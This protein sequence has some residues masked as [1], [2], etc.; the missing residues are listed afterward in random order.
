MSGISI[1]VHSIL[2]CISTGGPATNVIWTRGNDED[3]LMP[4]S[5]DT[6][7]SVLVNAATAQYNHTLNVSGTKLP[8]VYGCSV[9][10]NKPSSA[11][12]IYNHNY[13]KWYE[14]TSKYCTSLLPIHGCVLS[15]YYRV[16]Q[17]QSKSPFP[18]VNPAL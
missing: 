5:D 14:F 9:S 4:V 16:S 7:V 18:V 15:H 8:A 6:H 1:S 13:K 2:T 3:S 10:N 11:E 17:F 12:V